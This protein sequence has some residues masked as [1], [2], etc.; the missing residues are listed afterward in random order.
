MTQTDFNHIV[1][2]LGGLSPEQMRQLRRELDGKLAT[3]E[4][5]QPACDDLGSIGA[6][7]DDADLLDAAVAHAMKVREERPWR[8]SPGE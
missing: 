1:E 7:R 6:M 4:Q 5:K 8:L 3:V 2:S